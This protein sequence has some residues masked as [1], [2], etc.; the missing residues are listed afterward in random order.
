MFLASLKRLLIICL[1]NCNSSLIYSH[2]LSS[3]NKQQFPRSKG[4]MK[5]LR[6]A[7]SANLFSLQPVW[8]DNPYVM[9]VRNE[10]LCSREERERN[11]DVHAHVRAVDSRAICSAPAFNFA[12]KLKWYRSVSGRKEF[13]TRGDWKKKLGRRRRP[14]G[15]RQNLN[16]FKQLPHF[17][18]VYN[19]WE[20]APAASSENCAV[21][22]ISTP[23]KVTCA[24]ARARI[25][26]EKG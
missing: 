20:A 26:M 12:Q 16:P 17:P 23:S 3:V 10:M 13:T 18:G 8:Y 11:D 4:L 2:S 19:S 21:K 7:L 24:R 9:K 1:R 5:T 14:A 6:R 22:N 25:S 15:A